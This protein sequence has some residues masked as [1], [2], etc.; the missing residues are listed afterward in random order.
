MKEVWFRSRSDA[1]N[2]ANLRMIAVDSGFSKEEYRAIIDGRF[3][4]VPNTK[5]NRGGFLVLIGEGSATTSGK[6]S[7]SR[8]NAASM[9]VVA[10]AMGAFMALAFGN[11]AVILL[12]MVLGAVQSFQVGMP[13]WLGTVTVWLV[14]SFI[15]SENRTFVGAVVLPI[16]LGGIA[17]AAWVLVA[18]LTD[19]EKPRRSRK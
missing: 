4:I 14:D 18:P 13:G 5:D 9:F 19:S 2:I 6:S 1:E 10:V 12:V 3:E 8:S 17:I 7:Q 16:V 15:L 11:I